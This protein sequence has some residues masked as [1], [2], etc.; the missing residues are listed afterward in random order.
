M[1]TQLYNYFSQNKILTQHQYGFKKQSSASDAVADVYNQILFNLNEKKIAC[2]IFLDLGKAFHCINHSILL[3]KL[4]KYGVR[5]IP[6]QL[7][8]SYLSNRH[9]YRIVNDVVSDVN[10]IT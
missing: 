2:S 8:H 3:K 9:Q 5:A 4:E 6:L 10:K 7:F 1:H